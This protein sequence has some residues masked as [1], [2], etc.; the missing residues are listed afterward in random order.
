MHVWSGGDRMPV[1]MLNVK[2]YGAKGDGVTDDTLAFRSALIVIPADSLYIPPGT[3][4]VDPSVLGSRS[5]W[6]SGKDATV[7]K[8]VTPTK[9]ITT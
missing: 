1:T 8:P 6:G 5:I 3:Y 7:L 4:R 9:E 2:D